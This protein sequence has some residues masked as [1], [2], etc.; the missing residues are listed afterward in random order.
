MAMHANLQ[1]LRGIG[2]LMLMLW[3][4]GTTLGQI[5][6][7]R[8]QG[9]SGITEGLVPLPVE[10]LPIAGEFR[11]EKNQGR[12]E[13][14]MYSLLNAKDSSDLVALGLSAPWQWR[15][16]YILV[17]D[18][19]GIRIRAGG[20]A[21]RFYARRT[22]QQILD[23]DSLRSAKGRWPARQ[24]R[25]FPR[26]AWRGM[27]LDVVRHFWN[28]NQVRSYL[29]WMARYKFNVLHWHL[30]DDQ[31]WRLEVPGLPGL[32]EVSAWR[33]ATLMGRPDAVEDSSRYRKEIHGGFY[34]TQEIRDLVRYADSLHIRIVPE[35]EMPGHARAA[36]A[37]YPKLSCRGDSLPVPG[38][39][40]VFEDVFCA[41]KEETFAFLTQVLDHVCSLF[42]DS[43]V[44]L[45]GDECPKG[46]WEQCSACM[47]RM[48]SLNTE[49]PHALQS[50][51]MSRMIRY[52]GNKGKS[53]IGWDEILE[54]GLP[55]GAAVMS[56]R[57]TEGGKAA[58]RAGH[59]VVMSPGQ[60]CYF[61]HYQVDPKLEPIAIGG[62]NR[63]KE[64]Y[65]Y[66]PL[67]ADLE[68]EAA[69]WILGA[70][71]NVWSE[72]LYSWDKVEYRV[73]PRMCALSEVLWS[74]PRNVADGNPKV[75][76]SK[77]F[78]DFQ[79]RLR[80]H[81]QWMHDEGLH[82]APFGWEPLHAPLPVSDPEFH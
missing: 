44:H 40:G 61:D 51:F 58:S 72:Y 80:P 69:R 73:L 62:M 2:A 18:A 82:Y 17:M 77:Q 45:G 55:E 52:L 56:W 5:P 28:V 11:W 3:M 23:A 15:E 66:D 33:S 60:P 7:D 38:H 25:D 19:R 34:R 26:F 49:D 20:S 70:Q 8:E 79:R 74:R 1:W 21:G 32:T 24:V 16:A 22:L 35:I 31:G 57:G 9:P 48:Q 53:V 78:A 63:L 30:T 75:Q 64:V 4:S 37:A 71:G 43:M 68:P 29:Q 54:G 81:S 14:E 36:L 12:R 41:G 50:W 13:A 67:P 10:V 46:R 65:A 39:W 6:A 76:F 42:P 27:H 47:E 59:P